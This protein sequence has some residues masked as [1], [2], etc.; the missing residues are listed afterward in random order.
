V[1][2][3]PI[4]IDPGQHAEQASVITTGKTDQITAIDQQTQ[5]LPDQIVAIVPANLSSAIL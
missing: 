1:G 4:L 5:S 3:L 2:F